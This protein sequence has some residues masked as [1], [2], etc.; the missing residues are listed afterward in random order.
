[1][2]TFVA[3]EQFNDEETYLREKHCTGSSCYMLY[4]TSE[5]SGGHSPW[6][7]KVTQQQGSICALP[8]LL[9]QDTENW[10]W[11]L[12]LSFTKSKI[13]SIKKIDPFKHNLLIKC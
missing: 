7:I 3:V 2:W 13:N 5:A 8:S 4:I 10:K 12:L 11:K 1:M 6:S 9:H